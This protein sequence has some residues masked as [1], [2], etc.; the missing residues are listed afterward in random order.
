MICLDSAP[1]SPPKQQLML[2]QGDQLPQAE[3]T[4]RKAACLW[5]SLCL[6]TPAPQ[7]LTLQQQML[8]LIGKVCLIRRSWPL[9]QG[10]SGGNSAWE[11]FSSWGTYSITHCI[12]TPQ[13]LKASP[14][15]SL[16]PQPQQKG[17]VTKHKGSVLW[18]SAHPGPQQTSTALQD[19]PPR[20]ITRF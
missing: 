20:A 10:P 18:T 8:L 12:R 13:L 14:K 2:R 17:M 7:S 6:L 16:I 1:A 19:T 3:G 9:S 5:R 11:Y 4:W 15:P